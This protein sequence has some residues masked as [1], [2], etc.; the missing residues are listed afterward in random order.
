MSRR[1]PASGAGGLTRSRGCKKER[2][3]ISRREN[4]PFGVRANANEVG[5]E[6]KSNDQ[7]KD[8]MALYRN[9]ISCDEPTIRGSISK[10]LGIL[11]Q[12]FRVYGPRSVIISFNGGKDAVVGMHLARAALAKHCEDSG[13]NFEEQKLRVIYFLSQ[14]REFPE[15]REFVENQ[16]SK[17]N[18][19]LITYETDF[20]SGLKECIEK[21]K[22]KRALETTEKDPFPMGF[23]LGTRKG[24]PNCGKQ[25]HFE[26]SS[27]WMPAFMRINPILDWDYGQI[28]NFLLWA[29]LEYP[30]LYDSGYTSL[31]GTHDT[32]PNPHLKKPDGTY[33]PAHYLSDWT[34]ERA[35]R[36][37]RRSSDMECDLQKVQPGFSSANA[38]TVGLI[39][40]GDE[41]LKGRTPDTNSPYALVKFREACLQVK[42]VA[43]VPDQEDDIVEE[44]RRQ[45]SACDVVVTSGGLGPTHDDVTLYAVARALGQPMQRSRKME[46]HIRKTKAERNGISVDEVSLTD[47]EQAMATLPLGSFLRKNPD[48]PQA[49]PILQCGRVFVLPGVPGFFEEKLDTICEHFLPKRRKTPLLRAR[50]SVDELSIV[51]AL[52]TAVDRYSRVSFGSYPLISGRKEGGV[53]TVV[54]AESENEAEVKEAMA[55]FIEC[56]SNKSSVLSVDTYNRL[57]GESAS[58]D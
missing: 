15:V 50:L 39:V 12:A 3:G 19:D 21:E 35:G 18:L 34:L 14:E 30:S 26:P 40:V 5:V 8:A 24:D 54:T 36:D 9:L 32:R 27:D 38:R 16:V 22:H 45:V 58:S 20:V 46:D 7:G 31:G 11:S 42:R 28:W 48:K 23:V 4:S 53:Q 57:H 56:L 2:R 49:W 29:N 52:N 6:A 33:F 55:Y 43:V 37:L 25:N 44:L 10:S 41:I 1:W 51:S 17:F 47:G 13:L